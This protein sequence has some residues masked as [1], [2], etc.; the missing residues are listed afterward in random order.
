MHPTVAK[1]SDQYLECRPDGSPRTYV[2]S[3]VHFQIGPARCCWEEIS[4]VYTKRF[5]EGSR[6]EVCAKCE[7]VCVCRW[8]VMVNVIIICACVIMHEWTHGDY[9]NGRQYSHSPQD[10][11]WFLSGNLTML[12][13]TQQGELWLVMIHAERYSTTRAGKHLFVT[14]FWIRIQHLS[15]LQTSAGEPR[16]SDLDG[17]VGS[18]IQKDTHMQHPIERVP[19]KKVGYLSIFEHNPWHHISSVSYT[20]LKSTTILQKIE[21]GRK[22]IVSTK[23]SAVELIQHQLSMAGTS[24][25]DGKLSHLSPAKHRMW[26]DKSSLQLIQAVR[27]N[28]PP[29][30]PK[31]KAA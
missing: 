13:A 10:F 26:V 14:N 24:T 23:T 15:A 12:T 30:H 5:Y 3:S 25:N 21:K 4:D 17:A 16:S 9:A 29:K 20:K 11:K 1:P 18:S 7:C 27:L 22:L 28:M 6:T 31:A 8:T 19:K 2:W